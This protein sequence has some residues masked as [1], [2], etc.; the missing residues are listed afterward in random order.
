[1]NEGQ[2]ELDFTA[3]DALS[4]FRLHRLEVFNWGTFDARVWAFNPDGKNALLTGD[5][6]SGKSTLVDA[7]TT[8]LVPAHRIAYN[9]AAGAD[10]K[11][12]SLRSYVLG[13]YK[14]ERNE[15]SGS[16][17]PV[18]LR[19]HNNYSVILGVFHNAGYDQTVTLAQVFW[20][21]D[22]QSQPARFFV[23]AERAL[24]IS[25]DFSRFGTD[26]SALRKKLRGVGAELFDSFPP[27]G[28]WFRRRFG[29][30]NE[31]ALELFHQ[32][33]SMKSVGNLTDFVRSHMLEPFEV[34]SRIESLLGHFDNLNRAHEAVLKTKR[35]V[36]LLTPLVGDCERHALLVAQSEELRACRDALRAYFSGLKLALLD[37]R[38]AGLADD[39]ERQNTRIK[40]LT[41]R[42]TA[43]RA[44]QDELK[45]SIADNGG[46]RLERLTLEIARMTQERERREGRA[47]RY[48]KLVQAAGE[49]PVSNEAEFIQQRQHFLTVAE[50]LKTQEA[51]LQNQLT[52]HSVL[53]RQ[54]RQEHDALSAEINSLKARRSNIPA[55]QIAMR[56]ALCKALNLSEADM[57]FIGELL[58]VHEQEGDWEGAAERLLRNFGLSL[59]VPDECYAAVSAWVDKT[60]LRGRLVYFRIR[61]GSRGELPG[62]HKDSLARKLAIKPDSPFYDWLERELAHRFD[63][64][65]CATPEQFR[66]ETRAITRAGQ[67]KAP[68]ERHEKDDRHRLDDRSRYVLGWTNAAKIAALE[69]NARQLAASLG[70]LGSVIGAVQ[71][72]QNQL[73]ERLMALSKLDEYND[74]QDQDWQASALLVAQ[75]TDEK[76]RLESASDVLKQ[77]SER[78]RALLAE[79]A[80]TE[81]LIAEKSRE[82]GSTEAKRDAAESLRNDT[83]ALLNA[84]ETASHARYFERL[85]AIRNEALA[86]HQLSVESCDNREREMYNGLQRKIEGEERKLKTLRDKIIQAM[87]AYNEA[88]KLDT[89]EVD[90]SI[91]SAFE[92]RNML[93][94]LQADDLPRFEA[95]FKE[96]L[97]ENTIREVANFNSQLNRER[98]TIKERITLINQ[99]LTRIDYN[100]GR[101]IVLEAQATP[102]ADIRDFQTELRACTEGVLTGSEDS[103][104]S[105]NKFLQVKAII[106]RFRGCEGQ[107][108]PDRRWTAKVTDVRNWFVFAASER[109]RE[110]D[111]E[112]EHYSDSGG[113]SGGQKEKLA[114]TILAASLAY[115][116]GLEWGAVRSRSFRFVVIDEAFGRGSDESAQYGLRLFAQLNLQ[117]LIV[118]PLQ[119]IH[120]IEPFVSSVGFVHNEE[121]R[122]SKLRNLSI[123]EYR[124]EKAKLA[125]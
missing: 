77:L 33:V 17:K 14:S 71:S 30:D 106:E 115:Q 4:G 120:I 54:G 121:G 90:A 65:C 114:Y 1:M 101:Y 75:L 78:L 97:N 12:R 56:G 87:A 96:L 20:M 99:S 25:A 89:A 23:G 109:W 83:Q 34:A 5:I 47:R 108:E 44:E 35:Q 41:E 102:D 57:P 60:Q 6:G 122:A 42:Q 49:N 40:R 43:Q 37:K 52:E 74:F 64:A 16:A 94:Q 26:I 116:F 100:T 45:R 11:E 124:E 2:L 31:Q 55:E 92:Y 38:I 10:N 107:S 110:D 3:D 73:K 18:A 51:D 69:S 76:Q 63:V 72:Q 62:L 98:E 21:K 22:A 95:R 111:T 13:H 58:Q 39:W 29:I 46:D 7:V 24:S 48:T 70:Q 117:L 118:T 80:D 32:T 15:I 103:Q 59:L 113:K 50:T 93:D 104:Y 28:A 67:V 19:D 112:H 79:L 9:K 85:D 61:P 125:G 8:L 66:R 88:F 27:Y 123:E 53:L 82:L 36:E 68:G 91:E 86:E 119:K 81:N 105:E 84:A